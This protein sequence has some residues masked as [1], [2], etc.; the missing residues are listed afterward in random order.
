ML[1]IAQK[2]LAEE[3]TDAANKWLDKII[4]DSDCPAEILGTA[5]TLR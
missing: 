2:Y 1:T 4:A 3:N 5:Q